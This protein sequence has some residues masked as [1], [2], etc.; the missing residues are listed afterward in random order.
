MTS[1]CSPEY[2]AHHLGVTEVDGVPVRYV[3]WKRVFEL[4][5]KTAGS[6]PHAER[7]L[8]RDLARYL[9]GLMTMQNVTSNLV[10]VV[11]LGTGDLFGSGLSFADIVVKHDRYFHPLGGGRGGWPK[12]PPNVG[13]RFHG[14]LQQ[15]RHVDAYD[16]RARPWDDIPALNG[17]TDWGDDP[18]FEY[19]L[20][21][22]IKPA[23]DVKTGN[24]YRAQRVWA[25]L[26][27]LLTSQTVSEARDL[28]NARL[29][30]VG[31]G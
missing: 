17:K 13:F 27:L 25:A 21:P 16:I 20:G 12:S 6:G 29:E 8:L 10:Y 14:K 15:V 1:E 5:E 9:K 7:R 11:S 28:T 26:D 18:H 3:S 24:L 19:R 31:E 2:A 22:V 23:H 4:V 30:A